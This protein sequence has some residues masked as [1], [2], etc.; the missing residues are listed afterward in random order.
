MIQLNIT[1]LV[2]NPNYNE[3]DTKFA[4]SPYWREPAEPKMIDDHVL[5][6]EITKEQFKAIR[7][8]VIDQF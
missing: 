8:A 4:N 5:N 1:K 6:V 7:K 3:A 2:E